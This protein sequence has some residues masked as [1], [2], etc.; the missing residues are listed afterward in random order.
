MPRINAEQERE[1]ED[2]VFRA[3][4]NNPG[5]K[6]SDL[7]IQ[8]GL[9]GRTLNNYLRELEYRGRLER[10]EQRWYIATTFKEL[11]LRPIELTAEQAMSLYIATRAM[12][13]VQDERNETAGSALLQLSK[14]LVGTF[15]IGS[16]IARVAEDL[17]SRP[18]RTGY[19][20]VF[21]TLM[22]AYVYR[23]KVRITYQTARDAVFETEFEPSRFSPS[24][25]AIAYS[26]H[27]QTFRS[28]KPERIQRAELLSAD[29]E[30]RAEGGRKPGNAGVPGRGSEAAI[31]SGRESNQAAARRLSW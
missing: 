31:S 24:I 25:Y 6:Q 12:A 11:K 10:K 1:R 19:N 13:G 15:N 3:V 28:Y 18:E 26:G 2:I 7:E 22:R 17:A 5:L 4:Q 16:D 23:K 20:V 14:E 29:F 27:V 9:A 8:T 21:R 30:A